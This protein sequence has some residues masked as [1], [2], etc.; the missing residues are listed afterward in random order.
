MVGLELLFVV[1]GR[2]IRNA[3]DYIG[4]GEVST[5]HKFFV[6][7]DFGVGKA[8]VS[9]SPQRFVNLKLASQSPGCLRLDGVLKSVDE[10]RF[11]YFPVIVGVARIQLL[12]SICRVET[13]GVWSYFEPDGVVAELM[14]GVV[15]YVAGYPK[16]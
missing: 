4:A 13:D 11:E 2:H 5:Q 3:I 1:T 12:R 6:M 8:A 15:L 14:C 10:N 9:T 7:S 16:V